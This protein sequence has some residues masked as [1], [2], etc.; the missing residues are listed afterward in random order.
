VQRERIATVLVTHDHD[1]AFVAADRV[2]V[3]IDGT[4]AQIDAPAELW[5]RPA[6]L[7]VCEQLGFAPPLRGVTDGT[8]VDCG[9]GVLD[10]DRYERRG[11]VDVVLRP[12]AF[13]IDTAGLLMATV[14]SVTP[15]GDR[16]Q[17]Q[18]EINGGP[19]VHVDVATGESVGQSVRLSVRRDAV[20]CY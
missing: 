14:R 18:V 17:A 7:G 15:I 1:E 5:R 6:S 13:R 16:L 4:F 9:W 10:A 2:A 20:L 11:A 19:C 3:L 8:H 12:D